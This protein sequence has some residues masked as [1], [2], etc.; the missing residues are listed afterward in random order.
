ME[1]NEQ[2]NSGGRDS[3]RIWGEL[4]QSGYGG[5]GMALGGKDEGEVTVVSGSGCQH[6]SASVESHRC[7]GKDER[8]GE[9]M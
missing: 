8:G 3:L 7:Q 6:G 2:T 4:D 9:S 5:E 1:A